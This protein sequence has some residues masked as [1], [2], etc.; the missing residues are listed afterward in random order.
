MGVRGGNILSNGSYAKAVGGKQSMIPLRDL[1][2][3]L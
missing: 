1:Q 3:N 2:A